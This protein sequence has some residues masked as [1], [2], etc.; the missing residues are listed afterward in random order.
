ME[1]RLLILIFII[2]FLGIYIIP[3]NSFA[4]VKANKKSPAHPVSTLAVNVGKQDASDNDTE[5]GSINITINGGVPP[6]RIHYLST[7][8]EVQ[9][10]QG[11]LFEIKA[12][13]GLYVFIIQDSKKAVIKKEVEVGVK[14]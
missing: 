9:Q 6:Y 1:K 12:K 13:P 11:S 5:D 14:Q 10:T 4:Q 3:T 8:S 2:S 7:N